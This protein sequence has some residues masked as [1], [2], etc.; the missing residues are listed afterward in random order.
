MDNKV[1]LVIWDLDETFWGG[2][3]SEGQVYNPNC[4]IIKQLNDHGIINSIS[5]KNDFDGARAKL[6]E[7]GV[8]DFFVF[9]S[10]SWGP[11]G[12]S[13]KQIITD[14]QLRTENVVFIDDNFG[15]INEVKY[16]NPGIITYNSVDDFKNSIVLSD[17]NID[18]EQKRL[19]QYKI[20]E[21]KKESRIQYS[22]NEEFLLYSDIR[23]SYIYDIFPIILRLEEMISRTNQ[24]NFTKKRV[25]ASEIQE[26]IYDSDIECAAIHVKDKFGDYGICG[27]Y[28]YNKL[29]N[30]LIHF[31][32]S[33][34]ILN[35][36]VEN[37]VYHK[38][39]CPSLDVVG[40]VSTNLSE[41][42]I[43]WIKEDSSDV[44]CLNDSEANRQGKGIKKTVISIAV[45]GGCDLGQLCHYFN[46]R[47]YSLTTDFNYSSVNHINIHREHTVFLRLSKSI[48]D[49]QRFAFVQLPFLDS[50]ALDFKFLDRRNEYDYLVY[51][52]LM[53]YTQSLYRNK[54]NGLT[55]AYG[56]YNNILLCD[57]VRDF[58]DEQL[59]SFK[60]K[61]EYLGPQKPDD[62]YSDLCW[63]SEQVNC[64]IIF[65]NGAE[66][67]INNPNEFGAEERHKIMNKVLSSFV[68][69][70]PQRFHIIDVNRYVKTRYDLKDNIR[71]YDRR[72]Y[73]DLAKDIMSFCDLGEIKV[74]RVEVA[75]QYLK[76]VLKRA[77]KLL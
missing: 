73:I 19:L 57:K 72:V 13:V 40:P 75:S 55:V 36:G 71:H 65:L 37:Y 64:P 77:K 6:K 7:F 26:L 60:S 66:V 16:Y 69:N 70:N 67:E 38:L 35:L 24:L 76:G 53:N 2:V 11:K 12:E 47:K 5:S 51:T 29:T 18:L 43:T 31:L 59:E 8:W 74:N 42:P 58:S 17:Y 63:L 68:S 56:A 14:C 23:I 3:L 32:F 9:P 41:K 15:N 44:V 22:S 46:P 48:S 21:K 30:S 52:P 45:I 34:R 62:F 4:E 10:I 49:E 54:K 50:K 20:L 27:F 61:Y 28:A 25:G 39:G 1:K 33:C